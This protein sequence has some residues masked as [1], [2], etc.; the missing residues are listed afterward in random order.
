MKKRPY[1]P[2]QQV[3]LYDEKERCVGC[4]RHR[5]DI[6]NWFYLTDEKKWEIIAEVTPLIEQNNKKPE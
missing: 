1:N 6:D 2:C 5:D 4:F 3:C